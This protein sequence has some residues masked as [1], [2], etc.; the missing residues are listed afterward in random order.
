MSIS[1]IWPPDPTID[2]LL[3]L[4]LLFLHRSHSLL[5]KVPLKNPDLN[6][7][8]HPRYLLFCALSKMSI[9]KIWPQFQFRVRRKTRRLNNGVPFTPFLHPKIAALIFVTFPRPDLNPLRRGNKYLRPLFL[10]DR[11]SPKMTPIIFPSFLSTKTHASP[12]SCIFF[13]A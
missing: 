13:G 11:H 9:W 8:F 4:P 1:K 2:P 10:G 7:I 12:P 3:L 5:A 6:R